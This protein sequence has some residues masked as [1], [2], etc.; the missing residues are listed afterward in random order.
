MH[1][2]KAWNKTGQN[3]LQNCCKLFYALVLNSWSDKL[4]KRMDS[5]SF[6]TCGL[7]STFLFSEYFYKTQG[8]NLKACVSNLTIFSAWIDFSSAAKLCQK[9][10][11]LPNIM[12]FPRVNFIKASLFYWCK[13][14]TFLATKLRKW[15]IDLKELFVK[16][17]DAYASLKKRQNII[18]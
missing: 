18:K 10:F 11:S 6:N 3:L 7:D 13:N 1:A 4:V 16:F 9:P 12:F 14:A 8:G 15:L 2:L 17:K 5:T